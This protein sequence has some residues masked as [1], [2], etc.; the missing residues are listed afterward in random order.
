MD[1]DLTLNV[2]ARE[3]SADLDL[4]EVALGLARDEYAALDV[5]AGLAA[6]AGLADEVRPRLHGALAVRVEA[7]CHFLFQEQGF[8][9][10]TA[11][12]Y[13]A[14]NSYLNEVLARRTGIPLTLS[15][16]AMAVGGRAGLAVEGVGL[17][18]HFIARAVGPGGGVLF[19]PF[20]GGRLLTRGECEDLVEQVTGE[21]FRATPEALAA[22][23]AQAVVARL[24]TN[25]KA[26]YL[27]GGDFVRAA[28]V[29]GRLRQLLPDDPLQQRDLGA[30]LLHAGEP[31]RAVGHL[32]AY[33]ERV[34]DAEDAEAVRQLLR[35]AQV[36]VAR[37]N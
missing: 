3:P 19:D 21:P 12:Y 37:W 24:L 34:P 22:A 17:P 4:A 32:Q 36:E 10:N 27:R 20:H 18:G 29:I 6:L 28:R 14:R 30:T 8:R 25:L 1:L 35:K 9:G 26:I 31:G 16:V 23:T 2:L 7:L 5:A 11:D 15:L 33:L 13:D